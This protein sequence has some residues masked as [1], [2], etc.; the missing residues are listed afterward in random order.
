[1]LPF[2]EEV[3]Q[4]PTLEDMQ[5]VVVVKRLRPVF[6]ECWLKHSVSLVGFFLFLSLSI[7]EKIIDDIIEVNF[8]KC[9]D[10]GVDKPNYL[11]SFI[12]FAETVL[13]HIKSYV[14]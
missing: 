2:E 9:C 14:Q 6:R 5:D 3:G 10:Q 13:G 11:E 7:T 12:K 8:L 4:A 1:M